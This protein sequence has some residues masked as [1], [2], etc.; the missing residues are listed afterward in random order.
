MA[1]WTCPYQSARV[2]IIFHHQGDPLASHGKLYI[3][4]EIP[5]GGAK[6]LHWPHPSDVPIFPHQNNSFCPNTRPSPHTQHLHME[7]I[8]RI[9][10]HHPVTQ[11]FML[12]ILW[13]KGG[14]H[15]PP[16]LTHLSVWILLYFPTEYDLHRLFRTPNY[17]TRWPILY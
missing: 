15:R 6:W 8:C 9:T 14:R 3:L 11:V 1:S 16:Q 12:W 4:W 2:N 10:S 5:W 17:C 13:D 7:P